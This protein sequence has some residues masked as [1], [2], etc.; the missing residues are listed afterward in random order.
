MYTHETP[1]RHENILI[2]NRATDISCARSGFSILFSSSEK[3]NLDM[4][5]VSSKG[6]AHDIVMAVAIIIALMTTRNVTIIINQGAYV[7]VF[8]QH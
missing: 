3:T 5:L 1:S 7:P 2:I 8:E 6:R 4:A